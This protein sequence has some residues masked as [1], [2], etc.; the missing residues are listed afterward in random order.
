MG[1]Q[2][3]KLKAYSSIEEYEIALSRGSHRNGVSAIIDE[4]PYVKLFLAKYANRY[5]MVGPTINPSGFGFLCLSLY[6]VSI[7][8]NNSWVCINL[9]NSTLHFICFATASDFAVTR[10]WR[11]SQKS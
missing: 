8:S 2:E 7:P 10:K 5:M 3:Q 6:C 11:K 1:F 9:K 4:I